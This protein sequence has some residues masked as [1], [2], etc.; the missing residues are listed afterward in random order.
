[1]KLQHTLNWFFIAISTM[2]LTACGGGSGNNTPVASV[3]LQNAKSSYATGEII[4]F[5]TSE[6]DDN[7]TVTYED[8][9]TVQ[10]FLTDDGNYTTML[11]LYLSDGNQT[12]EVNFSGTTRTIDLV[13]KTPVLS[14]AP[15]T[16]NQ[17][18]INQLIAELENELL[19]LSGDELLSVENQ[20][21]DLQN[22]LLKLSDLSE[23]DQLALTKILDSLEDQI[24]V[25]SAKV[26]TIASPDIISPSFKATTFL[27]PQFSYSSFSQESCDVEQYNFIWEMKR[28]AHQTAFIGLSYTAGVTSAG[29]P[30]VGLFSVPVA[31]IAIGYAAVKWAKHAREALGHANGILTECVWYR[32]TDLVN[33]LNAKQSAPLAESLK[34]SYLQPSQSVVGQ[35]ISFN[36]GMASP[37]SVTTFVGLSDERKALINTLKSAAVKI[38][39]LLPDVLVPNIIITI[40]NL[41]TDDKEVT[42]NPSQL[43]IS[44]ISDS[45]IGGSISGVDISEF[46]F[47]TEENLTG[48]IDFS[49]V[50]QGVDEAS[51]TVVHEETI[52]ATLIL[53]EVPN[54]EIVYTYYLSGALQSETPY[55]NGV[56]EG[57][58]KWYYESG[59]LEIETPYVN[60][61]REG[62]AKHYYEDGALE[63]EMTY[64]NGLQ[65]GITKYY[66]EN[67]ILMQE[68]PHLNGVKE[69]MLKWYNVS[70]DLSRETPYVNGVIEGIEKHYY[71]GGVIV[72]WEVTYVNGVKEGL[73]KHYYSGSGALKS[74]FTN[75]NGVPNGIFKQYYESG[76]L[77]FEWSYVNGLREGIFKSYYENGVINWEIPY[78]NGLEHGTAK[79][80]DETGALVGTE[81][82]ING[83]S[84]GY[85]AV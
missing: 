47:T 5:T 58:R 69:G 25:S 21:Q 76:A 19:G 31:G 44:S 20:I 45:R 85:V 59:A 67:G 1:M 49:F 65:E 15:L 33:E 46:V 11:P 56:R 35:P 54:I 22:Y 72:A 84:Q 50:V 52:L 24:L 71:V 34:V 23:E 81:V 30:G 40:K 74:E 61:V 39:S 2:I 66:W 64:V 3:T 82:F 6:Q 83:V 13:I 8:G 51:G 48:E 10:T 41:N 80:Y 9:Q 16:Y 73:E 17:Q 27:E 38:E 78:I 18:I 14:V 42:L 29:I 79:S 28:V 36:E 63:I 75:V 32:T 26:N 77:W 57:I 68:V 37:L 53:L 70:G 43:R 4:Y 62:I 55:V 60:G 7:V 12:I